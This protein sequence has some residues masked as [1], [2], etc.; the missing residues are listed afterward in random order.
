[1][2]FFQTTMRILSALIMVYFLLIMARI[3]LS[4]IPNT[5]EG[6]MRIKAFIGRLT[7][8]YMRHFRGIGWLRFG[9]LDFSPVLGLAVLSFFL[10]LTQ[11]L[12]MGSFPSLGELLIW[13]IQMVWGIAAFLMTI[14]AIVMI[15]R[16]IT[17]YTVKGRRPDWIDRLDAFLFPRVSRILGIFTHRTVAYPVALGI[18][19]AALLIVRFS[20]GW[21]LVRY[22]Y[23]VL[24]RL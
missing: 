15:V 12:S 5:S 17:L 3:I 11:R 2:D 24:V 7:D 19:A 4:W 23:P 10:Y 18:S 14:L 8:P 9:M 6:T 16:L 21:V 1:M 13:L 20:V 22:L